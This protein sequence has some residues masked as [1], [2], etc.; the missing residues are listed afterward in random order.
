MNNLIL[1][2]PT[3]EHE[4][5][6]LEYLEEHLSIGEQDLHGASLL[7]K[8]NTYSDW[9]EH[10]EQQ[11]HKDTLNLDWVVSGTRFAIDKRTNRIIGIID[12]RYELNAF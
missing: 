5:A 11:S 1:L 9:L 6:A 3:K 4:T 12:I 2:K 8:M 10:L 7:E